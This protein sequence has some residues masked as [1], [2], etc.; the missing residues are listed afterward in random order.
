[1]PHQ[2]GHTNN[3]AGRPKGIPNKKTTELRE[4]VQNIIDG[5]RQQ[6]ESDLQSLEPHQRIS[7]IEK[8]IAYVLPKPQ[9][10]DLSIEYK[11][12]ERL[13]R[14]TPDQYIEKITAKILTLNSTNN[15]E[16]D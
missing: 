7:M 10:L 1:M 3:P 2:K 12:L 15:E 13:L 11:E 8:L 6:F 16:S 9:N 5:N 14:S 4:W